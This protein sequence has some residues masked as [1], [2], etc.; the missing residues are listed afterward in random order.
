MFSGSRPELASPCWIPIRRLPPAWGAAVVAVVPSVASVA[1]VA[2]GSSSPPQA[3]I[4][5]DMVA[6]LRPKIDPR[7]MKSRREI[8]PWAKFSIRSFSKGL[9]FLRIRS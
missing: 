3:A 8:E 9:A 5:I 6:A 7:L 4:T 1:S 2:A